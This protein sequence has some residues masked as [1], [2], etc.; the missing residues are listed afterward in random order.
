MVL[1]GREQT[2]IGGRSTA[3]VKKEEAL[4]QT[5]QR[6]GSELIRPSSAL[7]DYIPVHLQPPG[8][9]KQVT[10]TPQEWC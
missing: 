7:G 9:G 1:Y 3:I 6:C 8:N 10:D 5:P 2:A 4:P